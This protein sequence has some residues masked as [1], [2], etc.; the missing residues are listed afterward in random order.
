M[1][2]GTDTAARRIWLLNPN[3]SA[4]GNRAARPYDK[5]LRSIASFHAS[6]FRKFNISASGMA[7]HNLHAPN[8]GILEENARYPRK[9]LNRGAAADE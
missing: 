4:W 5:T 1:F 6:R 8:A 3:V 7:S 9:S 2:A